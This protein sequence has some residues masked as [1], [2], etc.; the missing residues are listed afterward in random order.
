MRYLTLIYTTVFH[1]SKGGVGKSLLSLN[2]A[3]YKASQGWE[4]WLI[5]LDFSMGSIINSFPSFKPPHSIS[6]WL[7]NGNKA[8]ED[9]LLDI[10]ESY[11]LIKAPLRLGLI[12][13]ESQKLPEIRKRTF[14]M[15]FVK[16]ALGRLVAL[17]ERVY[18]LSQQSERNIAIVFDTT[19]GMSPIAL[20]ASLIADRV[21]LMARPTNAHYRKTAE[22][23]QNFHKEKLEENKAIGLLINQISG[24]LVGIEEDVE[25]TKETGE[26][27]TGI[28]VIYVMKCLCALQDEVYTLSASP[29]DRSESPH[30][31]LIRE[32]ITRACQYINDFK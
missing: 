1:S 23:V 22:L 13:D 10:S 7:I 24:S 18:E 8:I 15:D 19:P 5:E 14:S 31:Q 11:P 26:N 9:C 3:A 2:Y 29:A 20:Q 17:Q 4:S 30:F 28:P 12:A 6:E 32:E 21:V 16:K 27:I 25:K